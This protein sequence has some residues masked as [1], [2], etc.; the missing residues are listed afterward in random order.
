MSQGTSG[1]IG[2]M[3]VLAMRVRVGIIAEDKSD[4]GV[5]NEL[6]SKLTYRPFTVTSFVGQGCG[7]L[8]N[9]SRVWAE[10]LRAKGCSLLVVVH[11]LDEKNVHDLKKRLTEALA[12]CPISRNLIVIP[13]REIEAW[14]LCDAVA[15]KKVFAFNRKPKVPGQPEAVLN[16]K[17]KLE[18]L[19]FHYS[20]KRRRY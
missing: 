6:I 7:K 20:E 5:A 9:K 17:R 13:I 12:P 15:L 14:L 10:Q 1:S 18:E 11:D 2:V 8:R 19:V 4:V 16:P 3:E